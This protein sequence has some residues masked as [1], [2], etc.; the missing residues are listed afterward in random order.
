MK[1]KLDCRGLA[2]PAPVLETK[3]AI[4]DEQLNAITIILDNEASRQNV[5]RFLESQNF[6]VSVRKIDN[7]FH[8]TGTRRSH[9]PAPEVSAPEKTTAES[10]KIMLMITSHTMGHGDDELG[11]KLIINLLKTLKEMGSDLWRLVFVNS[12]VYLTIEGSETYPILREL[13]NDGTQILVCGTCLEHFN[14]LQRNK[15]GNATNML[16]IVT[17]MQLADKVIK[18]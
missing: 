16:D 3:N 7:D 12:G 8:V 15:V 14:L 2:C 17:S 18:I 13:E 11:S 9:A 5:C 6:D 1:K 4:D 10:Q